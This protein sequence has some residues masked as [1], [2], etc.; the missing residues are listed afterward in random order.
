[1]NKTATLNRLKG[2]EKINMLFRKSSIHQTKHLL[3]RVL[4]ANKKDN[5]LYAGVSVPKRNFKR[6]VDRNRI[7]RQLR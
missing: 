5:K 6:A 7:K 3:I 2:K 1:M 4:E